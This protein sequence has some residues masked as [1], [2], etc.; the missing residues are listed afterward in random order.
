MMNEPGEILKRY[1]QLKVKRDP[2]LTRG[3]KYSAITIPSIL[4]EVKDSASL[5]MQIDYSTVGAEYV[6]HLA[7]VYLDEMF[8]VHRCFFKLQSPVD[9]LFADSQMSGKSPAEIESLYSL[10]EREARWKFEQKHSRVAILDALKHLI[11]T[12]NA[13][14]YVLPDAGLVQTYALDEYMVQRDSSGTVLEIL[15]EDKKALG[16]CDP[17]LR[18]QIITTSDTLDIN[19]EDLNLKEVRI[20]THIK[21]SP[22]NKDI[23]IV[24]QSVEGVPVGEQEEFHKDFL[25]WIVCV[26]DRTRREH[27]GRGLVENH[28]GAFYA[29]SLLMETLVI[30]GVIL[31]DFKFLVKPGS[32]VDILRLN[33]S[34]AG[35]YH[36][37]NPEDVQLI[38]HGRSDSLQFVAGLVDEYRKQLGKVFLVLSS[39][40]RHAERVEIVA[41]FKLL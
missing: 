21:M 15:T 1:N 10:T 29:L 14:L 26:W 40:L 39:Q 25:P 28:Y 24:N 41:L 12:G 37:G 13:L 20:L 32:V 3:W 33:S 2:Y 17:E 31:G 5:E 34:H 38:D 19:D 22:D 4:P 9:Q 36:Y 27:Y 30:A 8:P 6:N 23:Y 35:S 16:T 7:N 18:D 11:I